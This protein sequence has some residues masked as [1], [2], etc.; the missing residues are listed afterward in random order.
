MRR[1]TD[2]NVQSERGARLVAAGFV[3]FSREYG[4]GADPFKCSRAVRDAALGEVSHDLDDVICYPTALQALFPRA[5][6]HRGLVIHT[7]QSA[8]LI[9]F[10]KE[11]RRAV[12]ALSA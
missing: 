2:G 5:L 11:V 9:E 1:K 6:R 4:V 3:R 10:P 7:E 8:T 12:G